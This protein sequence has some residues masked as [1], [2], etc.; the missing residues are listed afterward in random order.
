MNIHHGSIHAKRY[1][2]EVFSEK[3]QNEGFASPDNQL[4]CWYRIRNNV[5]VNSIV[6]YS[7][8]SNLPLMLSVGYGIHPLFHKPA[9][10]TRLDYPR[11]PS[12]SELLREQPLIESGAINAMGYRPFS[13]DVQVMA[14]GHGGKGIYTFEGVILPKMKN[15]TTIE[16]CYQM[17]KDI[18]MQY[19]Y[20]NLKTKF[21]GIASVFV[22]EAI[23]IGDTEMYPYCIESA[24]RHIVLLNKRCAT[25]PLSKANRESLK[26]WELRKSVLTEGGREEYLQILNNRLNTNVH[27]LRKILGLTP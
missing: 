16:S 11:K 21:A 8:W 9:Y 15:A 25:N 12:D 1:I 24:E 7:A 23:Y 22:D 20:D 19:K 4:L 3:L 5:I 17:H 14:P 6:F 26:E 2:E 13:S 18:R 27:D 10:T